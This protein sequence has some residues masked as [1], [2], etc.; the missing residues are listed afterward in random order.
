MVKKIISLI[1]LYISFNVLNNQCFAAPQINSISG[2]IQN[3]NTVIIEG[4]D[5]GNKEQAAPLISSFD[6]INNENNWDNPASFPGGDWELTSGDSFLSNLHTR[7]D[8]EKHNYALS[9]TMDGWDNGY[10]KIN[11]NIPTSTQNIYVSWWQYRDIETIHFNTET[12]NAKFFRLY[13][14]NASNVPNIVFTLWPTTD[15]N[16]DGFILTGDYLGN[17]DGELVYSSPEC[18]TESWGSTNLMYGTHICAGGAREWNH[19]EIFVHWPS[20]PTGEDGSVVWL[21]DGKT[22]GRVENA[23]MDDGIHVPGE[24]GI[25]LIGNVTGATDPVVE[26]YI[27][28]VYIDKTIAHVYLSDS[29]IST[30]PDTANETHTENQIAVNWN[31]NSISIILNQGSFLTG[32]NLYLYVVNENGLVNTNG[33]PVTFGETTCA[34]D[35]ESCHTETEC[36]QANWHWCNDLCQVNTCPIV[37]IRADVDQNGTINSVDALLT[38][39]FFL[40][41]DM[42]STNWQNTET[43]GDVNCDNNINLT[44]VILILRH[45]LGLDMNETDW[46]DIN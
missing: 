25:V 43:T 6:N 42:T 4:S 45:S 34:V 33:Y 20:A 22:I 11:Y 5:F 31:N 40:N 36:E 1:L 9:C 10:D 14:G 46:C 39:R 35:P 27:S 29:P 24:G 21:V 26:K 16:L 12:S 17:Q 28:D 15:H 37:K 18:A 44:D 2:I 7:S 19:F 32:E 23:R 30:W 38:L 13:H 8:L 41:L 3:K